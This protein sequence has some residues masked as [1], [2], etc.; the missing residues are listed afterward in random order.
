[1]NIVTNLCVMVGF[2]SETLQEAKETLDYFAHFDKV[3]LPYYFS[4]KYYPGTE[5]LRT[6][7][8]FGIEIVEEKYRAPYH[9]YQFQ[10]TP[11][12]SVRD[13]ERLNQW[14]LRKIYLNR[15]RVSNALGILRHH[16]SE[17]E[18]ADMFTVFFRRP[19]AD[20]ARDVLDAAVV[21]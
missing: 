5:I 15:N 12:I 13:F 16:Y 11:E 18:I 6:A 3:V 8:Q 21:A 19:I 2:P 4:V 1:M 9:G 17:E 7:E 20:L 10:E 14:Y